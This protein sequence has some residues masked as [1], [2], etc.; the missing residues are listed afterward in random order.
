MSNFSGE[1]STSEL[2]LMRQAAA[3]CAKTLGVEGDADKEREIALAVLIAAGRGKLNL[4]QLIA[5]GLAAIRPDG[6]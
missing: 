6:Q 2:Q 4:D 5:A 3:D 1:F